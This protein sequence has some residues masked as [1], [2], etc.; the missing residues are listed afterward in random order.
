MCLSLEPTGCVCTDEERAQEARY[1]AEVLR[2]D[3]AVNAWLTVALADC[4]EDEGEEGE[5]YEPW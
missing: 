5:T 3:E 1:W 4:D 2:A